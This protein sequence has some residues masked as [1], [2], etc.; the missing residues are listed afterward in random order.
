MAEPAEMPWASPW[1]GVQVVGSRAKPGHDTVS[2][3]MTR[4]A[5]P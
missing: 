5:Q 4:Q 2:L 1:V 3:A